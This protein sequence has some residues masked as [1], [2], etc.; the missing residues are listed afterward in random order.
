MEETNGSNNPSGLDRIERIV[1]VL[2]NTQVDMQQ[3]LK[4]VLRAQVILGDALEKLTTRVT[5]LAEAQKH[6]DLRMDA[7]I[8]TVDEIVRGRKRE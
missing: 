5:E 8:V 1:E 6:T 3:D 7:L 4:I 2:A